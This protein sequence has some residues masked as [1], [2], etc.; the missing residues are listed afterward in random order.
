MLT[1]KR[2]CYYEDQQW[3]RPW[4][5]WYG[6]IAKITCPRYGSD[7]FR[8]YKRDD[9]PYEDFRTGDPGERYDVAI[10]PYLEVAATRWEALPYEEYRSQL[11]HE[12]YRGMEWDWRRRDATSLLAES[13]TRYRR[14][15]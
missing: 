10:Q 1:T 13:R 8:V 3:Y 12:T 9:S 5:V 14:R 6:A 7:G 15:R 11:H 4:W 2:I